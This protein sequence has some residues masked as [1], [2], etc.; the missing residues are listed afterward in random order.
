[1]QRN[2]PLKVER[3]ERQACSLSLENNAEAR[4]LQCY[5]CLSGAK[6]PDRTLENAETL[7]WVG[8]R[9][10]CFLAFERSPRS[11]LSAL[12]SVLE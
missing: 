1:M 2:L 8:Q 9:L 12:P 11:P 10:A 5:R 3:G 4:V 7:L 6:L